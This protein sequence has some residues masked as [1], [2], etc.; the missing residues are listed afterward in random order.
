MSKKNK[1]QMPQSTAGLVRYFDSSKESIK[2]KPEYVAI[3][4]GG[5]IAV[6]ILLKLGFFG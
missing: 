6:E 1:I 3:A 2:F 4:C 5:I